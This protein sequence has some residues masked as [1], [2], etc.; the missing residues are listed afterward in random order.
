MPIH[1]FHH[2]W[3]CPIRTQSTR[4][5]RRGTLWA[6]G[7][8]QPTRSPSPDGR[9]WSAWCR[10]PE[11]DSRSYAQGCMTKG[12][13]VWTHSVEESDNAGTLQSFEKSLECDKFSKLTSRARWWCQ[14]SWAAPCPQTLS[15]RVLPEG[16]AWSRG[17]EKKWS[18][19]YF[20]VLTSSLKYL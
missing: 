6:R 12:L 14:S 18:R 4:A 11:S 17:L 15:H 20:K 13:A 8:A 10:N 16:S 2:C 3:F 19:K 7:W 9:A 1:H 5:H